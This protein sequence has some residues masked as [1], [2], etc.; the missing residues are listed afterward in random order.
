MKIV[1]KNYEKLKIF[2]SLY[3]VDQKKSVNIWP[4]F[5]CN[6]GQ[7]LTLFLVHPVFFRTIQSDYS[8]LQSLSAQ[9]LAKYSY[10]CFKNSRIFQRKNGYQYCS[11]SISND[12]IW[13]KWGSICTKCEGIQYPTNQY[14]GWMI[15]FKNSVKNLYFIGF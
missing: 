15:N 13:Y 3:R 2:T 8:S 4:L 1:K 9:F 7:I 6:K 12:R 14:K 5:H 10:N 11:F